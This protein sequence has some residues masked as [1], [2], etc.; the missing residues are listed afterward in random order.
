MALHIQIIIKTQQPPKQ[1]PKSI[2][3]TLFQTLNKFLK[4]NTFTILKLSELLNSCHR[5]KIVKNISF[6]LSQVL[7][8]F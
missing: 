4:K 5:K 3:S 2:R 7:S 6:I 8:I 1:T